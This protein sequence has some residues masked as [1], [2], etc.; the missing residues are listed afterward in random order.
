MKLKVAEYEDVDWIK[1]AQT[2]RL[3]MGAYK[4]HNEYSLK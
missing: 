2:K 1:L 4:Y 3:G